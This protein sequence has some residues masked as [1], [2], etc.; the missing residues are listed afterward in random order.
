LREKEVVSLVNLVLDHLDDLQQ[1][2]VTAIERKSDAKELTKENIEK[3]FDEARTEIMDYWNVIA[4]DFEVWN[5][6]IL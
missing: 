1:M 3:A 6:K 5:H 4:H 2:I